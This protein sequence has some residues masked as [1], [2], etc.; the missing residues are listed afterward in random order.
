M[1][2]FIVVFVFF[3]FNGCWSFG[4]CEEYEYVGDDTVPSLNKKIT[5]INHTNKTYKNNSLYSYI[6]GYKNK[7][8]WKLYYSSSSDTYQ[9]IT[10]IEAGKTINKNEKKK[11][12]KLLKG[13]DLC[14]DEWYNFKYNVYQDATIGGFF[15]FS[16]NEGK[17][18]VFFGFHDY[19]SG[20]AVWRKDRKNCKQHFVRYDIHP[21]WQEKD[22]TIHIYE[23]KITFSDPKIKEVKKV[24]ASK[25]KEE[26]E[27]KN[28]EIVPCDEE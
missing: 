17:R 24:T 3:L 26:I 25:S 19:S 16:L 12:L 8:I 5:I 18:K 13:V 15:V 4:G 1:K 7:G 20:D 14:D 11:A 28:L 9:K 23:D 2:Y 21:V 22:L 10:T 27:L 6:D